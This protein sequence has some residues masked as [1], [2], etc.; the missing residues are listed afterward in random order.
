MHPSSEVEREYAVRVLGELTPEQ[1]ERL[2]RG[3]MLDDGPAKFESIEPRGGKG[4]NRWYQVML[5]EGRNREVRRMLEA[6][7][8][9]V[10]RLIRTRF[11]PFALPPRLRRGASLELN[12][13]AVSAA[14]RSL[15]SAARAPA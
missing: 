8:L 4:V 9:G 15:E 14:I 12:R 2:R 10:S 5:K 1:L 13:E 6:I 7:G 11:G 3:V